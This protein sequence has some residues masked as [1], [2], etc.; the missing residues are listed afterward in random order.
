LPDLALYRA[1]VSYL[2]VFDFT[3]FIYTVVI[4][5]GRSLAELAAEQAID[6]FSITSH[7]YTGKSTAWQIQASSDQPVWLLSPHYY[8]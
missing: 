6:C 2:Y 8:K 4:V 5:D 3:I 1:I 7:E